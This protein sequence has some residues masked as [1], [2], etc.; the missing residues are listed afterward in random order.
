MSSVSIPASLLA[1]VLLSLHEGVKWTDEQVAAL[2]SYLP[3]APALGSALAL[4]NAETSA[5][6][7]ASASVAVA[8]A[9]AVPAS[10]SVAVAVAAPAP[11]Q[12]SKAPKTS[13]ALSTTKAPKASKALKTT[14]NTIDPLL[15][16]VDAMVPQN[17]LSS[18]PAE[19]AAAAVE[20][21]EATVAA[22]GPASADPLKGHKYRLQVLDPARCPGRRHDEDA[23]L[24]GTAKGEPSANGKFYVELQCSKKA[25]AGEELCT[26]CKKN[27][28]L[29][30]A[31]DKNKWLGR[32]DEPV[33]P[34]AFVVGSQ[35]FFEKY[36]LGLPGDP[37]TA[38]SAEWL[39]ANPAIVKKMA[40]EG[41]AVAKAAAV[42]VVKEVAAAAVAAVAEAVPVVEPKAFADSENPYHGWDDSAWALVMTENNCR[43]VVYEKSTG[44]C[45][46]LRK[47]GKATSFEELADQTDYLGRWDPETETVDPYGAEAEAEADA[48]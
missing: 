28:G 42:K 32:L 5:S 39:A 11:V 47:E 16:P 14:T 33:Y 10:A 9:V 41:K 36:P 40:K 20:A 12:T 48:E 44:K 38:A 30:R 7:S 46:P 24:P 2:R 31:N 4:G 17:T 43:P 3:S 23:V 8:V 19:P 21:A 27:Y 6:A 34:Q 13:K 37:S 22:P 26:T 15:L 1:S 29:M 35:V 25:I 45:Y 18:V